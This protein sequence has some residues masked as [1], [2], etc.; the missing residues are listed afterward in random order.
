MV[1]C[2]GWYVENDNGINQWGTQNAGSSFCT[3]TKLGGTAA[4]WFKITVLQ[5][6]NNPRSYI[7]CDMIVLTSFPTEWTSTF[8]S[9][10]SLKGFI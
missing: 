5:R 10:L 1:I 9:S 6:E 3:Y 7:D 8:K 4:W 2:P